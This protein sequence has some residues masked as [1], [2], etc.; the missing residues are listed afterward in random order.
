[1]STRTLGTNR[2]RG[3]TE[4]REPG[5]DSDAGNKPVK[6]FRMGRIV[7]AVFLNEGSNGAFFSVAISRLYKETETANW[8]RSHSF[9]RDDL[10]IVASVATKAMD[11]IYEQQ[12]ATN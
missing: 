5:D 7:A 12:Q 10:C 11:Y 2:T 3:Q 1:M 6:E 8:E 9:G 4:R